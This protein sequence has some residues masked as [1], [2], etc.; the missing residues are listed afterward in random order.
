M[1]FHTKRITIWLL[2]ISTKLTLCL[3]ASSAVAREW[4]DNTG[5][6][7]LE[8]ELVRVELA[9]VVLKKPDGIM[10][11]VPLLQ[12]SEADREY[13][14]SV[15]GD[16][17][18]QAI[19]SATE[20]KDYPLTPIGE[21]TLER[22]SRGTRLS[23][24]SAATLTNYRRS[25]AVIIG[26]DKYPGGQSGLQPLEFAVND[27]I[28]VRN[29]LRDEFGYTKECVYLLT[30]SDATAVGIQDAFAWLA[31][32]D[33]TEQDGVIVFFSGHGLIDDASDAGYLAAVD[34]I[35]SDAEHTC[36]PAAWVKDQLSALPCRHKLVILDS[37]Y[38]G[39]LFQDVLSS[40]R[41]GNDLVGDARASASEFVE[42]G[43][44]GG[45]SFSLPPSRF[46]TDN[47]S[48]YLQQPAFYGISAGRFTPVADG[49]G[50]DRHS[51]F[52]SSLLQVLRE[53]ANSL[54]PDH[55]FTF[56]QLA[57]Q[58]ETR[59]AN[60]LG[61]RQIPQWGQLAAGD[62][63]FVFR[64]TVIR[65]TPRERAQETD[66]LFNDALNSARDNL[67]VA[68]QLGNRSQQIQIL[69]SSR[70]IL[71]AY[72]T[73]SQQA[74]LPAEKAY[75]HV[76]AWKGALYA[77][78]CALR[79]LRED[80]QL[81][82]KCDSLQTTADALARLAYSVP[83]DGAETDVWQSKLRDLNSQYEDLTRQLAQS[84][85]SDDDEGLGTKAAGWNGSWAQ[86]Q[87]A[88]PKEA[89]IVDFV[90]YQVRNASQALLV[91]QDTSSRV[92]A[93]VLRPGQTVK[94][95]DL[96]ASDRISQLVNDF[97]T[98][99][100][101]RN[102]RDAHSA[103][104][105]IELRGVVWE[106]LEEHLLGID[107][108]LLS[109]DGSLNN[110]AFA[111]L[112]G[113]E[114]GTYLLEDLTIA[115][116]PVPQTLPS[117]LRAREA[118]K[119]ST[120]N[121]LLVG[122]PDFDRKSEWSTEPRR[123]P[124]RRRKRGETENLMAEKKSTNKLFSFFRL[125]GTLREL[126]AISDEYWDYHRNEGITILKASQASESAFRQHTPNHLFVHVA[127][128][129]FFAP[130]E[131]ES[132]W[133]ALE[134]DHGQQFGA[135][136]SLPDGLRCGLVFAGVNNPL[137]SGHDDGILTALEVSHLDLGGVECVVLAACETAIGENVGG[138]GLQ[139]L[140]R[141]FHVAGAQTVVATSWKVDD[142]ATAEL[143]SGFYKRYLSDGMSTV[144]ALRAAQLA[145]LNKP[146]DGP[147]L[148]E[149]A[150]RAAPY[151]WAGFVLS[152]DWR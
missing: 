99:C 113:R 91:Q 97:A 33:L 119:P 23:K 15:T 69:R 68:L 6:F 134:Q 121:L 142:A 145:M 61:S 122:D 53:R 42:A 151:V 7:T 105:A 90:E 71:D 27:A 34:S 5:F 76:L 17:A 77:W 84:L 83:D 9:S 72:L 28:E 138:E 26:I 36:I 19:P 4:R 31:K 102:A 60:A 52:S 120:Q 58:V 13:L 45:V 148:G 130:Q 149:P 35:A 87:K 47:L 18:K 115:L 38:S 101:N 55:T 57:A 93:F 125:P 3:A 46:M 133:S 139:S 1:T 114:P 41:L 78:D 110:L 143:M 124:V 140:Q 2:L 49:L 11:A 146:H 66:W 129:G 8:A 10:I 62:G 79:S 50:Q 89:A 37:C 86:I 44:R 136:K 104:V 21:K 67:A 112:P 64:P 14:R 98:V 127:T 147:R 73:L 25:W 81:R 48:Y 75:V 141:A 107:M 126:A 111:A 54:R 109:P 144:E 29:V 51:I 132:T 22:S 116:L 123:L 30:D 12:L 106:P 135:T 103:D 131:L 32:Q 82:A 65:V 43:T 59:V 63:D 24:Q 74:D 92:M 152:G 95:V 100:Q 128:S 56:R 150:E 40:R 96:G 39:S 117:I 80:P 20:S 137:P 88:L 16:F 70:R 94:L 85:A 118:K 108:V